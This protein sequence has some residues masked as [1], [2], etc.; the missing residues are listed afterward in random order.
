[1]PTLRTSSLALVDAPAEYCTPVWSA[2]SHTPKLDTEL[3][4]SMRLVSGTVKS[5]PISSLPVLAHV[6]PD[7]FRREALTAKAAWRAAADRKHL[8]HRAVTGDHLSTGLP[9]RSPFSMSGSPLLGRPGNTIHKRS[10]QS[11]CNEQLTIEKW[12]AEWE[13]DDNVLKELRTPSKPSQKELVSPEPAA[14]RPRAY[15]SHTQ[16]AYEANT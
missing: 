4:A 2:S 15:W 11:R 1:M 12:S 14:H 9:S 13:S 8:L 10:S 7:H 3:N 5:T 16:M 6:P